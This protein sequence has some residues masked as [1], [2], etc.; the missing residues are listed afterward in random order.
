MPCEIS[1]AALAKFLDCDHL[2]IQMQSMNNLG[3]I[4]KQIIEKVNP[5]NKTDLLFIGS[6]WNEEMIER[7]SKIENVSIVR[8]NF[9]AM[10][11]SSNPEYEKRPHFWVF[12]YILNHKTG[13]TNLSSSLKEALILQP[14][15]EFLALLDDRYNG[16]NVLE[17]E[18]LF[19][20]L[21]V[22]PIDTNACDILFNN[23]L[24]VFQHKST[25][26]TIMEIGRP[27][28]QMRL[29]L[30]NERAINNSSVRILSDGTK[31]A[32]TN[33]PDLVNVTHEMLHKRYPDVE[34]TVTMAIQLKNENPELSLS[35]RKQGE[36]SKF[37][38][39][40]FVDKINKATETPQ[41]KVS[42]GLGDSGSGGGRVDFPDLIILLKN[43]QF[44][45][46]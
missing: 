2:T 34:V 11:L 10:Q 24:S 18:V 40:E 25:F 6:Y 35:I 26:K 42:I 30:A 3:I 33:A 29:S 20:G 19:S 45:Q 22:G 46:K 41:K 43:I 1:L 44:L 21:Y 27:I 17:T 7:L 9:P 28:V 16:V 4:E 32:F 31:A 8:Y 5:T 12:N 38:L 37:D 23:V 15:L 14:H 39:K 36:N 13:F